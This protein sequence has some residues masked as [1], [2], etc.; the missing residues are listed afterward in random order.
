MVHLSIFSSKIFLASARECHPYYGADW[1]RDEVY[2]HRAGAYL[3][4]QNGPN[5]P[6]AGAQLEGDGNGRCGNQ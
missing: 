5:R 3:L 4:G 6:G 1:F 2:Y